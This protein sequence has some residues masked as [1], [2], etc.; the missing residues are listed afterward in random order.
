MD[1]FSHSPTTHTTF[2][3]N[4]LDGL[5]EQPDA[6]VELTVTSPPYPMIEMWDDIFASCDDQIKTAIENKN[7]EK[8]HTQMH[9]FLNQIWDEVIRVTKDNCIIAINIGN[10]TRR[11]NESFQLFPNTAKI[12]EHFTNNGCEMLPII[13]W[14]KASNKSSSFMGS[15]MLPT[16]AYITND[17]EYILVFRKG[18]GT[19]DFPP[20]HTPRY[21]SAYFWEERNNWFS[22]RW[23][24]Q[25]TLQ[26]IEN[27]DRNRSGAF[28][29]TLP[30]RIINMYSIYGD[31]I[32]DPFLGTGTTQFVAS[33][34]GRNSIG[35]ELDIELKEVLKQQLKTLTDW[36]TKQM[37]NR[38]DAHKEYINTADYEFPYESEYGPVKTKNEQ[39][40]QLPHV[41]RSNI[42]T[43][44]QTTL[45]WDVELSPFAID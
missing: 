39:K 9:T 11:T 45:E 13:H 40:I 7:W 4:A 1:T 8:A 15:G 21:Q 20:K 41:T 33:A 28:P 16:N 44:T 36:S 29:P 18:T 37:E 6:S 24:F 30:Y 12:I 2:Y 35:Y 38:I 34:L 42:T 22:D 25:G 14:N 10:A 43:D 3:Q 17:H 27:A 23:S 19:R 31:T 26:D 5:Q 32:L